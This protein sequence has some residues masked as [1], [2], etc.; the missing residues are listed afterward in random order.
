MVLAKG[1]T[2][3]ENGQKKRTRE[4]GWQAGAVISFGPNDQEFHF[5]SFNLD[6]LC[7]FGCIMINDE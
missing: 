7:F 6:A 1:K 3:R 4:A 2:S 5:R